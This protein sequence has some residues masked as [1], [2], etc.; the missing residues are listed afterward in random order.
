MTE[1]KKQQELFDKSWGLYRRIVDA[2]YMHHRQFAELTMEKLSFFPDKQPITLLD[3]G[4]GDG[5]PILP[6]LKSKSINTYT[7][8]DLSETA[9]DYCRMNLSTTA[10]NLNLKCGDMTQLILQEENT[11]DVIYS[12]Y[13]IHHLNDTDKA[14]LFKMIGKYLNEGG[15]FIYIDV[16]R[17]ENISL[18]K[19][20]KEYSDDILKWDIVDDREKA[21]VIAH[22]SEFDKPAFISDIKSWLEDASLRI[23]DF[24]SSDKK[25]MLLYSI[26]V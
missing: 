1:N 13:A 7:G 23:E 20:R 21:E 19:Y 4:C 3:L 5:S 22:I 8:Y 16:F 11:F 2:D 14:Y 6:I 10:A 26:K 9:I 15:K 24:Y 12:S 18:E 17:D 25:H